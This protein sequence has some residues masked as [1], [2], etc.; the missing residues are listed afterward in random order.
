MQYVTSKRTGFV[1]C[2][3]LQKVYTNSKKEGEVSTTCDKGCSFYEHKAV[4]WS[5]MFSHSVAESSGRIVCRFCRW[6]NSSWRFEGSY[7]LHLKDPAV[8]FVDCCTL[9]AKELRSFDKSGFVYRT[10]QYNIRGDMFL[11]KL[12]MWHDAREVIHNDTVG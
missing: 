8:C 2:T 10:T 7:F 6:V 9:K 12:I 1:T 5:L 3:W 4:V 11:R